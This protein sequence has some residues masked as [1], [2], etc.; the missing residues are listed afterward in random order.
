MR[1]DL[2]MATKADRL[3]Q[4]R[5][6]AGYSSA[7]EAADAFGWNAPAYRHH[8]NGTRGFGADAARKYGRAFKVRPGWLLGLDH[9]EKDP[10]EPMPD[11]ER[12]VVN[13]S[14]E[15]GAW[16]VSE[17][18]NDERA[19]V[20]EG[21]PCPIPGAK[22]FGLVVVGMSMNEFYEPGTVLDC[23][24]IFKGGVEPKSG[25]HV[26]VERVRPDGLRELTVKEYRMEDGGYRLV[27]RSTKPE[28][29][30]IEY[31]G[32]DVDQ[33]AESE[34]VEVIGFVISAYPPRTLD[35]MRRM[36][37]VKPLGR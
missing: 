9:V 8:E 14:V 10:A 12:L 19:F 5:K 35:L 1:I 37:L 25:D 11:E 36:G 32:P 22:R 13:G 23:V 6:D 20:I 26:I 27:P 29:Q 2:R 16:R 24:S 15:A 31:P 3:R 4:A 7:Q 17:H 33:P 28:F 21:M 18:W 34:R 30:P